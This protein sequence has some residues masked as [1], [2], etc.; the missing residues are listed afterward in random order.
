MNYSPLKV[1]FLSAILAL[2]W[3]GCAQTTK[4]FSN[5]PLT[6]QAKK[7]FILQSQEKIQP[8]KDSG[9]RILYINSK[10]FRYYDYVTFKVNHKNEIILGLFT[11][12]KNIGTIHISHNKICI[13]NDCAR[14]WPAAK[15]FFG[16]VSYGNLFDDI[17]FG[18]NIFGGVGM[19]I[20]DQNTIIQRFQKGGEVIYYE[21]SSG[22]IAF[23][24][25]SNGV[26]IVFDVYKPPAIVP[27]DE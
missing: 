16:K 9:Y 12:G 11:S 14:K 27:E 7:A 24:N 17:F 20:I 2:F 4:L 15:N 8:Q 13:L 26:N 22:H 10:N 6:K 25:L 3:S 19:K 23:K 21:R 5:Q 18:R 1:C